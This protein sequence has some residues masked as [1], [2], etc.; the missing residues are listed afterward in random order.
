MKPKGDKIFPWLMVLSNLKCNV[1]VQNLSKR[2]Q[3]SLKKPRFMTMYQAARAIWTLI[4]N[5]VLEKESTDFSGYANRI[6]NL[7]DDSNLVRETD[8]EQS[9][10]PY[11]TALALSALASLYSRNENLRSEL[12]PFMERFYD[13]IP[14]LVAYGK[15]TSGGI[16]FQGSFTAT[17]TVLKGVCDFVNVYSPPEKPDEDFVECPEGEECPEPTP[18][19]K[20]PMLDVKTIDRFGKYIL[21][22]KYAQTVTEVRMIL[23]GAN[24]LSTNTMHQPIAVDIQNP[25]LNLIRDDGKKFSISLSTLDGNTV[26]VDELTVVSLTNR[27]DVIV[28]EDI[29]FIQEE[30]SNKYILNLRNVLTEIGVYN[31]DVNLNAR[32]NSANLARQIRVVQPLL[33]FEATF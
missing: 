19:E 11:K 12:E 28:A 8:E 3:T 20:T 2:L 17:V 14:N 24:A 25:F 21:S 5:N 6:F 31:L 7:L 1:P 32:E 13:I 10:S 22:N 26:P 30:N 16:I 27:E 29:E 15:K 9:G 4:D 18:K 33:D 23:V